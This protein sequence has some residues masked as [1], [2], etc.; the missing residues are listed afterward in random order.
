MIEEY[1]ELTIVTFMSILK[2]IGFDSAGQSV[3]SLISF[4]LLGL[5]VGFPLLT[6]A[7]TCKDRRTLKKNPSMISQKYWAFFEDLK[8]KSFLAILFSFL[9]LLRRFLF[10]MIVVFLQYWPTA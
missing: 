7:F 1:L 9:F 5:L 3:S 10:G 6:L 8:P 2:S 4:G